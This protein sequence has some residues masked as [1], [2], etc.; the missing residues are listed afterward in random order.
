MDWPATPIEL[1]PHFEP[2]HCPW[3]DCAEHTRR[4]PGY[5]FRRHAFYP[6]RHG[7]PVPRFRCLHCYRTFSQQTFAASYYLK[8]PELLAPIA[9]GLLAGSAHRQ[10]ARSLGCAPSTVTRQSARLGRH[11]ALLLA[12]ALEALRGSVHEPFGVDHF[13]TFEFSQDLPLGVFTAVGRESWFVYGLDPAPHGRSGKISPWQQQRLRQ[14]PRRASRGGY[15]GSFGRGVE[16]LLS[17]VRSG[18]PVRV[19]CD[20]K[21]EYRRA[22]ARS[23]GRA[24]IVLESHPNPKRGPKGTPRTPEAMARDEAM[25]AVDQLHGLLRHSLAGHKRETIAFGRRLNAIMERMFLA[26]V[27]R[28]FVKGR[29]ERRPDRST[30]AMRL[31]LTDR[32]WSWRRVLSRRLYVGRASLPAVWLEL[33]RRDW[34]T[35]VLPVNVRHRLRHAA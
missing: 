4:L 27:W 3:P 15:A 22:L 11:S 35:P 26:A 5:R 32:V 18:E 33:Y 1:E 29:S 12:L 17:L 6:R 8:R 13:E 9:A 25:Y 10:I 16:G 28:N 21:E 20:G 19:A 14:R 34:T 24:R 2:P 30:P 23:E 31:G 7:R